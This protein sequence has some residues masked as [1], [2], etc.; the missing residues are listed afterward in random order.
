MFFLFEKN[1]ANVSDLMLHIIASYIWIKIQ[2]KKFR[3][4]IE[5]KKLFKELLP[6]QRANNQT[7]MNY[8]VLPE[9]CN[10]HL[11]NIKAKAD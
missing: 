6:V 3:L 8:W 9:A 11:G 10:I 2:R 4:N 1:E 5:T 7:V